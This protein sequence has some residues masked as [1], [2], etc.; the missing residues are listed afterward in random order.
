MAIALT[1]L[2]ARYLPK[3]DAEW[4]ELS[5]T[6]PRNICKAQ[7]EEITEIRRYPPERAKSRR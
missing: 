1:A 6:S 7:H 5:A 4:I 3:L 2:E